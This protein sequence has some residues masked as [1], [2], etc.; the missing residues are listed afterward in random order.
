MSPRP[1]RRKLSPIPGTEPARRALFI[2]RWG[3]LI[4]LPPG[5]FAPFLECRIAPG[6]TDLLFRLSGA[7]W[8]LYLIGNED[9]VANGRVRDE[10]WASFER[11]ML[12]HLQ[13][14]GVRIVR[15]YACLEHPTEGVGAHKR[16]SVFR[17]P[18]TGIF[19]HARQNDGVAVERSFL[20]GDSTLEIAAGGRA[21]LRTVGVATGRGCRDGEYVVEPDIRATDLREA[22][23]F[24]LTSEVGSSK[25][26]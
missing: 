23:E 26:A 20:V 24:F 15:N 5:G 1:T 6:V 19:F 13:G 12:E 11:S 14:Q 10:E 16:T 7:G 9:L 4:D 17:L 21:G 2:D 18:D 3:T 22:L 25:A 8:N